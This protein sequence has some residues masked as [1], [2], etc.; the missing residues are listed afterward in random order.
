VDPR[1]HLPGV[2]S[3]GTGIEGRLGDVFELDAPAT[4]ITLLEEPDLPRTERP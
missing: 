2:E 1:H 4:A 3:V